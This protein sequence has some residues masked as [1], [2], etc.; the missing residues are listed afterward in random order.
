VAK[1]KVSSVLFTKFQ[2]S[3][4]TRRKVRRVCWVT[5][6]WRHVTLSCHRIVTPSRTT[7]PPSHRAMVESSTATANGDTGGTYNN[8]VR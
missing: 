6:Q 5:R 7:P 3:F 2:L 8:C 4:S 1:V